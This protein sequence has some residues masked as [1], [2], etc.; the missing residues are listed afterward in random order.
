MEKAYGSKSGTEVPPFLKGTDDE[1]PQYSYRVNFTEE[2]EDLYKI[3][4]EISWKKEGQVEKE[5][6]YQVFRR[7]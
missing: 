1:F 5:S 3:E 6:F 7:R 4:L 2:K